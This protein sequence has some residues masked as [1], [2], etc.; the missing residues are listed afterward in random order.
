VYYPERNVYL[1]IKK[2]DEPRKI[3]I[4]K[5]KGEAE[6]N[7]N[8]RAAGGDVEITHEQISDKIEVNVR[9]LTEN[10]KMSG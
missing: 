5:V 3:Y 4:C 2:Y 8:S 9:I 10:K 6:E 7:K 1:Q